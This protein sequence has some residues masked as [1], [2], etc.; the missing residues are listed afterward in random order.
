MSFA[1]NLASGRV[2]E[3]FIAKWLMA[4]GNAVMPAYEIEKSAGKGPQLFAQDADLVAPDMLVFTHDGIAWVE[5]KHKSV[6]T[7][8]R[9]SRQW[10][11]GIDLRHYGDYLRVS[12]KTKLPVWLLFF[13]RESVPAQRDIEMGCPS[14]CP[15]G[16]FG[17][18]LFL[19]VTKE[20]HRSPPLDRGRI[21]VVGHG[22]SGMVYWAV[23]DLKLIATK[24]DVMA[25]SA[26]IEEQEQDALGWVF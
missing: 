7:W 14:A 4:R 13:H 25:V 21:G 18:E 23:N 10:T 26:G 2:A 17:G 1:Q 6:F 20:N 12:K 9:V 22:K 11:T 19:L 8:H 24:D 5:S 15:T 16:L 3:G